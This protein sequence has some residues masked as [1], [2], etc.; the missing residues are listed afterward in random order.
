MQSVEGK[1]RW[2]VFMHRAGL[3]IWHSG[4]FPISLWAPILRNVK[5]KENKLFFCFFV[6]FFCNIQ[7]FQTSIHQSHAYIYNIFFYQHLAGG[8][9]KYPSIPQ[10]SLKWAL[11]SCCPLAPPPQG[12]WVS[13]SPCHIFASGAQHGSGIHLCVVIVL[14][15]PSGAC[16]HVKAWEHV[17]V[18]ACFQC[19][20]TLHS[21]YV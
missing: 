2:M 11:I 10:P 16:D 9:C 14:Y 3:V 15:G 18:C 5:K 17:C 4:D 20:N 1:W 19:M 21:L 13:L 7:T 6:C 12:R 8:C